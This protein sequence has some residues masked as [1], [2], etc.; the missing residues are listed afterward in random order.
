MSHYFSF[1][2]NQQLFG[3]W[4]GPPDQPFI[5][6]EEEEVYIPEYE[7]D[8]AANTSLSEEDE[9]QCESLQFHNQ[10]YKWENSPEGS[11]PAR[12]SGPN[13]DLMSAAEDG[14]VDFCEGYGKN[15]ECK[16]K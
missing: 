2:E 7:F 16:V 11:E 6:E 1:A 10:N 8:F 4:E 13:R 5:K 15:T 3:E 12:G 9:K 14:T